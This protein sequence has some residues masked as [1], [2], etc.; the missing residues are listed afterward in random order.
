MGSLNYA[1][2]VVALRQLLL[3]GNKAFKVGR[4]TARFLVLLLIRDLIKPWLLKTPVEFGCAMATT[5]SSPG[6]QH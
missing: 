3:E 1:V 2:K 6:H 5:Y 4:R